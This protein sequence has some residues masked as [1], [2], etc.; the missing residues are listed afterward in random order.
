MG[1]EGRSCWAGNPFHH[2]CKRLPCTI[3]L[4]LS[5]IV[6]VNSAQTFQ[7]SLLLKRLGLCV[8]KAHFGYANQ[9]ACYLLRETFPD[10]PITKNLSFSISLP[11]SLSLGPLF[12]H[13]FDDN[14]MWIYS[15][16]LLCLSTVHGGSGCVC[17][18][19]AVFPAP[20]SQLIPWH[21]VDTQ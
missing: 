15:S 2:H 14:L 17:V 5:E 13:S 4:A 3:N 18:I 9:L 20:T 1:L 8:P 21:W 11:F 12:F 7:H 6:H 16:F 10:H 19:S